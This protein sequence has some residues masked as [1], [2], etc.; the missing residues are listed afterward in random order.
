MVGY[1]LREQHIELRDC[2][3]AGLWHVV[4][5]GRPR[6]LCG[7]TVDT[8]AAARSLVELADIDPRCCCDPCREIHRGAAGRPLKEDWLDH[9]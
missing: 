6:A 8:G 3:P 4:E 9:R 7:H 1:E 5:S 2:E